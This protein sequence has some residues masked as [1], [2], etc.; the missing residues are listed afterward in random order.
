M[1]WFKGVL[2]K[3]VCFCKGV[4][5]KTK[6][7]FK[8][9]SLKSREVTRSAF[10]YYYII[11][12]SMGGLFYFIAA[13]IFDLP[14][15]LALTPVFLLVGFVLIRFFIANKKV[16]WMYIS[17]MERGKL[18]NYLN[19]YTH[20]SEE[21]KAELINWVYLKRGSIRAEIKAEIMNKVYDGQELTNI[22]RKQL[23]KKTAKCPQQIKDGFNEALLVHILIYA[24]DNI[25]VL[26]DELMDIMELT[27]DRML[28]FDLQKEYQKAGGDQYKKYI[29]IGERRSKELEDGK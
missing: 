3:F 18:L 1:N 26:D 6:D 5:R 15:I 10:L 28:S 17:D 22:E 29:E 25:Q 4:Y 12:G 23:K 7:Y 27:V 2:N 8:A 24:N 13:L 19:D 21:H 16:I 9:D 20:Y 14:K 11:F